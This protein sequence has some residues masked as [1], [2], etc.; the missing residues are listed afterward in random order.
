MVKRLII[1][2]ILF[3]MV[4]HSASRLG[5]VSY[6]YQQRHEIAYT[7]GLVSEV[8][9]AMCN[10][11]YGLNDNLVIQEH[12]TTDNNLPPT[13]AHA[14]EI[15]LIVQQLAAFDL[16][17]YRSVAQVAHP[18]YLNESNYSSPPLSIFHP[19]S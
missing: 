15:H 17:I 13:I 16:N 18:L 12:K 8:P 14:P 6:L 19:P 9:I 11:D 3:S 1:A 10:S 7:L 4:L 5:L 2:L